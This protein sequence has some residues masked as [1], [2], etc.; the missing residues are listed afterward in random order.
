MKRLNVIV[1]DTADEM[2]NSKKTDV[3]C[4]KTFCKFGCICESIDTAKY[5]Q[6]HCQRSECMFE[7]VCVNVSGIS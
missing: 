3:V 5:I 7:C 1:I 4:E 2:S 6:T